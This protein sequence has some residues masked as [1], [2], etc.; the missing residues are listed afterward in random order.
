[1]GKRYIGKIDNLYLQGEDTT[2][3]IE[4]ADIFES[5]TEPRQRINQMKKDGK[6]NKKAK[7]TIKAL[8]ES[9]N[10]LFRSIFKESASDMS[11]EQY[12]DSVNSDA[13]YIEAFKDWVRKGI[14]GR[15]ILSRSRWDEIW[16]DFGDTFYDDE[17]EVEVTQFEVD[18]D[19]EKPLKVWKDGS[20]WRCS[21]GTTYMGYL[22]P[23]DVVYW[24]RKDYGRAWLVES[25]RLKERA[26][27]FDT[28]DK[29]YDEGVEAYLAGKTLNEAPITG[30]AWFSEAWGKR[31]E[32]SKSL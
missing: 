8:D 27:D 3:D 19:A 29:Y 4:E 25:T 26:L 24:L 20:K 14:H 5:E 21:N 28:W 12:C 32:T 1:M 31:V 22:K 30:N 17:E 7:I 11:L 15:D 18:V 10:K 9:K 16:D 23:T 2:S 13:N 6:L